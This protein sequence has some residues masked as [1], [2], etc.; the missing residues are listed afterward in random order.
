V[1]FAAIALLLL[2]AA[3]E[4]RALELEGKLVQGGIAVGRVA[5]G[6]GVEFLGRKLR[7][8]PDGRFAI[9][10]GRDFE[11]RAVLTLRHPDGREE[12]REFAVGQ[13]SYDV[14][15]IDGLPPKM[16]TPDAATLERIR[17][18]AALINAARARETELDGFAATFLWPATGPISGVFG[19]QRILN[20]EPRRPHY[21]IDV[22]APAG[23][24]VLAPAPGLVALAEPDLYFT[25]GT[26]ILDHGHGLTSVFAHM[27]SLAVRPGRTVGQGEPI[28]TVG[29]TGRVT[30]AHLHWGMN[31][32]DQRLDPA[33]LVGPMPAAK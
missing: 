4:S 16:V 10:F 6:T 14:Q 8:A 24:P 31:W 17:R 21:G 27:Q 28:G 32:F 12:R 9:G 22:A 1:R 5:P 15:R 7:V 26:V 2:L 3:F 33:L 13:R 20:G 29:A 30:G 19:S 11:A 18:E 23:T 25:G